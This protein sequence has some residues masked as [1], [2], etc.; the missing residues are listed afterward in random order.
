[1]LFKNIQK[2][3]LSQLTIVAGTARREIHGNNRQILEVDLHIAPFGVKLS[4]VKTDHHIFGFNFRPKSHSRIAFFL[5]TVNPGVI[6]RTMAHFVCDICFL[7][8]EFLHAQHLRIGFLKPIPKALGGGR[9]NTVGVK[10]HDAKHAEESLFLWNVD[11]GN[12]VEF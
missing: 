12:V 4:S 2:A 7:R 6:A 5:R 1:M 10:S 11:N 3:I 9:T 8:F